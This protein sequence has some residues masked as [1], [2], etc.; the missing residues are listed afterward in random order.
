[1]MLARLLASMKDDD[2]PVLIDHFYD[3]IEPL[4]ETE[5]RAIAEAPAVDADLMRELAL[6]RT[7]GG[8][9][10]LVELIN[11]PSLNVRGMSSA[12]TGDKA[13]NVIPA[14]ATATIDIRLVKGIDVLR[15]PVRM[16]HIRAR[17]TTLWR[18]N[19]TRNAHGAP[20]VGAR[21]GDP[22]GY[23]ACGLDGSARISQPR[24]ARDSVGGPVVK[25]RRWAGACP[26]HGS[27]KF[28]R[29][30][31]QRADRQSRQ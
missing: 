17:A 14:T 7:E 30:D 22:G 12:R 11:L 9:K 2:G 24:C 19:P 13:S 1:M 31:H 29:A 4:T 10:K 26:V 28:H 8:G 25:P 23:N 6:G 16:E 21:G 15:P 27:R 20:Q 3:G 5:K 18:M